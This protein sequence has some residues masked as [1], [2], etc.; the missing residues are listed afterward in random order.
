LH[1]LGLGVTSKNYLFGPVRNPADLTLFAGGSSGGTAAAIAAGFV[2]V[3]LGS[4]TGGSIRIPASLC[5]VYGYR[6]TTN[7]YPSEGLVPI[8]NTRDT[9]GIF[10]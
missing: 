6:P 9:I 10:G 1:E 8:S 7:R 5:G 4:D 3:G 2:K